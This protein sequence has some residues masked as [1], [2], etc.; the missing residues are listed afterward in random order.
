L[1][2]PL[3]GGS[4]II[5]I[6]PSSFSVAC[7]V[8]A[9]D[10]VA[11]VHKA[12]FRKAGSGAWSP[13]DA[14]MALQVIEKL[15]IEVLEVSSVT[16]IFLEEPVM[17]R[18]VKPTIVQSYVSGIVQAVATNLGA[19][20]ELVNNKRWKLEVIGNGNAKKDDTRAV[21]TKRMK[22]LATLCGDDDDLYDAAGIALYGN[23]LI[24]QRN[25]LT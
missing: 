4:V 15:F 7:A 21:L 16:Q 24:K 9:K 18:S 13:K 10:R 11:A 14:G 2:V 1:I 20:L 3:V 23:S 5:G 12:T 17:G 19:S 6:D 25:N 22:R 8:V